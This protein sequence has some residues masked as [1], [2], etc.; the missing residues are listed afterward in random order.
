MS[1]AAIGTRSLGERFGSLSKLEGVDGMGAVFRAER[2]DGELT[3]VVAIKAME[4][5][6]VVP[7]SAVFLCQFSCPFPH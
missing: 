7:R 2:V 1:C 5:R 6:F 3:Q 4:R